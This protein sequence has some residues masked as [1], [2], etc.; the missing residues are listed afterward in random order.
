MR[1][2]LLS[3]KAGVPPKVRASLSNVSHVLQILF[4]A[5]LTNWNHGS[6]EASARQKERAFRVLAE[7]ALFL[8]VRR[9]EIRKALLLPRGEAQGWT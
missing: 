6:A 4:E 9:L 7:T 3:S 8:E 5:K 2:I 1:W